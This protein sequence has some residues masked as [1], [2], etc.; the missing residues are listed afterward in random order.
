MREK[1]CEWKEID[2]RL[3]IF[4]WNCQSINK[5]QYDKR[6][7]KIQHMIKLINEY[8]PDVIF[9]ID[10]NRLFNIGGNYES[11]FDGRNILFTRKD[12]EMKVTVGDNMNWMEIQNLKLG[13]IYI[14]PNNYNKDQISKKILEWNI[15]KYTYF[16]D[17]NLRSNTELEDVIKWKGG[18][19]TL[20][21][22]VAGKC[23]EIKLF[24]SPS[25]HQ[26]MLVFI[27]RKVKA[28]SMIDIV[29]VRN[30]FKKII[31]GYLEGSVYLEQIALP[32]YKLMRTRYNDSEENAIMYRVIRAF[33]KGRSQDVYNRFGWLWRSSRKEPFLGK[34]IPMKI[35]DSFKDEMHH[36]SKK[37]Y[38]PIDE[39]FCPST[40]NEVQ[41][42]QWKKV[43]FRGNVTDFK[44]NLKGMQGSYSRA[45]TMENIEVRKIIS[46]AK[47]VIVKWMKEGQQWKVQ[48][49]IKNL[50]KDH[51]EF[52]KRGYSL[53]H[54]TFF[55]KK[56][57]ILSSYRDVRMIT[58]SPALIRLYEALIYDTVLP[59]IAE[60]VKEE[61]YQFGAFP[62][63][64]TYDYLNVLRYKVNRY[65]AKGIVSLDITKGYERINHKNL[66]KAIDMIKSSTTRRLLEVWSTMVW[67]IDYMINGQLVRTTRGIPMGLALS[68]LI[69]VLYLHCAIKDCDKELV[70][71]YMDDISILLLEEE[72]S[73]ITIQNIIEALMKFGLDI[74]ERKSTIF[75][76]GEWFDDNRRMHFRIGDKAYLETTSV[77][78]I[79]GRELSWS[80]NILT[81]DRCNFILEHKIPKI[82]PNWMTLAMRR[83]IYIGGLTAKNRYISYMWAFKRQDVKQRILKN[84]YNF[85]M[86]NFEQLNYV[87]VFMILPNV[88]REFVDPYWMMELAKEVR[89]MIDRYNYNPEVE[90]DDLIMEKIRHVRNDNNSNIKDDFEKL[91][92]KIME[93]FSIGMEQF[94]LEG[95]LFG[96]E[97]AFVLRFIYELYHFTEDPA[98]IWSNAKEVL[99]EMWILFKAAKLDKWNEKHIN[100]Y[101][102]RHIDV[103]STKIMKDFMFASFK[104]LNKFAI[105]LDL[106][107][108]KIDFEDYKDW[109]YF[110]FDMLEKIRNLC[111]NSSITEQQ[112]FEVRKRI[113]AIK[114][115]Q[116]VGDE[117]FEQ[118]TA[119]LST[120]AE[121]E[122]DVFGN[123]LR[124]F[125]PYKGSK[126]FDRKLREHELWKSHKEIMRQYRKIL[127]V[128]D[129]MYASRKSYKD[130][131]YSELMATFQLKY[132]LCHDSYD[133]L[134]KVHLIQ[135]YEDERQVE[136][137]EDEA[138]LEISDLDNSFIE[139]PE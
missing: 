52:I 104:S 39:N 136:I 95:N 5:L 44:I 101:G 138:S 96:Y 92:K 19:S 110:V 58:I 73:D 107:F 93:P 6:R 56:N 88:L 22:G 23:E 105:L 68:P 78:M 16:G 89:P 32:R 55:L 17:F 128:L 8:Y 29:S 34:K 49:I 61:Q 113:F 134:E 75:T 130:T 35:L 120:L 48:N 119:T 1:I 109:T 41:L 21:T 111:E 47:K 43:D 10:A 7:I 13:F 64:S 36:D 42:E 25:D 87:Q 82:M 90:P 18:E 37:L 57:R 14:V 84:A 103:V 45:F 123:P 133:E 81:G 60:I 4:V 70:M 26:A 135:D 118:A 65:N 129:S 98:K 12:I 72:Q 116:D 71:A 63:S 94:D 121:I 62:N 125:K 31:E 97:E 15:K 24:P 30:K 112:L 28:S 67:N 126:D 91:I 122:L 33:Y 83:L 139:E 66:S 76:D 54:I 74:N 20:Q 51:N 99:N 3:K 77:A 106:L 137:N 131:S 53:Y 79:L 85:F 127:F 114:N 69:F 108:G 102:K 40:F 2:R 11:S 9:I 115:D 117:R 59:D 38:L 86:P 100:D 80:E 132:W 124:R 50:I 27:K 46:Y